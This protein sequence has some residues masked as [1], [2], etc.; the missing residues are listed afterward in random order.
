MEIPGRLLALTMLRCGFWTLGT[1]LEK[2]TLKPCVFRVEMQ[3]MLVGGKV[4]LV[5]LL[6]FSHA[7]FQG[8]EL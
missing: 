3:L 7:W 6:Y 4:N 8:T 2:L 1:L 5:S